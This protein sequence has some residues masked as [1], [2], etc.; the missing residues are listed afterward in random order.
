MIELLIKISKF[1]ILFLFYWFL[2]NG[3]L[4]EPLWLPIQ[5]AFFTAITAVIFKYTK[6]KLVFWFYLIGFCYIT[7]MVLEILKV[8]V[9]PNI[10]ASTGFGIL[11]ILII[12]RLLKRSD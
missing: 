11:V 6:V 3:F 4:V 2:N 7:S 8:F 10:A 5:A 1:V 9:L 12:S